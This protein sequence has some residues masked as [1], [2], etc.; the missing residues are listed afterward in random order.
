[1]KKIIIFILMLFCLYPITILADGDILVDKSNLRILKGNTESFNVNLY[2]AAGRINII[3]DNPDIVSV[4]NDR[5]F[6]DM[7][8]ARIDVIGNNS[9]STKITVYAYDVSTY[10]MEVLDGFKY[11]IDV[12]VY[13]KG[14]INYNGEIDLI[15]IISLLKKYLGVDNDN[16]D[17]DLIDINNDNNFSLLD[18]IM[19]LR[20]YLELD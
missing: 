3:S 1:M 18:V 10:D 9:G 11:E 12:I 15:D 19:L 16:N 7:N 4:N 20:K 17:L 2:N 13:D 5:V 14:D 6:L 8:M